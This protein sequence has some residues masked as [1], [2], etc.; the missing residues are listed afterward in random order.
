MPLGLMG[1]IVLLFL[2]CGLHARMTIRQNR[3]RYRDCA[4]LRSWQ[5][6]CAARVALERVYSPFIW[7]SSMLGIALLM[8]CGRL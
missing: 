7:I 4:P 6:T 1:G 5:E 8:F 3:H 2:A